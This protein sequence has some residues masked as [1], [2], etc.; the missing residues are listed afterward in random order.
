VR[1]L[2]N[3]KNNADKVKKQEKSLTVNFKDG[4]NITES[5][6]QQDAFRLLKSRFIHEQITNTNI[7][8]GIAMCTI[9]KNKLED[10][11][12]ENDI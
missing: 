6:T 7:A 8:I 10:W 11:M 1:H 3:L 4:T 2:Y 9:S 5:I 12:M